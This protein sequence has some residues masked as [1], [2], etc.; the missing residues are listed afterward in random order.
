MYAGMMVYRVGAALLD[1]DKPHKM[2]ARSPRCIFK[3]SELYET[4][5]LVPNIV[6]PTGVLERGDELWV[7]Y[8]AADTCICLAT[9]KTEDI[10]NSLE[11]VTE[12]Y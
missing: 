12:A 3:A 10:L 4:T 7:Y 1:M 8:G 2:T 5:G 11:A 6:F 9:V